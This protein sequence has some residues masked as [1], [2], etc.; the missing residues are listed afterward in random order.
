[1]SRRKYFFSQKPS[2]GR[3]RGE[4]RR[5]LGG[6][7]ALGHSGGFSAL[8]PDFCGILLKKAFSFQRSA[9]SPETY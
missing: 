2:Q 4:R 8:R 6:F 9:F 5:S 3:L 7:A 1:M